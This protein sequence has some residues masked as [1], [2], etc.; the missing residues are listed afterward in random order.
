MP[1]RSV[2][3]RSPT[4]WPR[5]ADR[6]VQLTDPRYYNIR[7]LELL[8]ELR[9]VSRPSARSCDR[10]VLITG[11]GGQ[12]ARPRGLR[13]ARRS[14]RPR[15]R[16]LDIT[17]DEAVARAFEAPAPDVVFNCAAFHN[18]EVCERQEDRLE[19]NVRAVD[20]WRSAARRRREARARVHQLRLRRHRVPSRTGGRTPGAAHVYAL[21]KLAGEYAAL[22]YAP[23]A[24]V[25]RS[26]G[27][28]GFHGSASQGRQLRAADARARPRA[29]RAAGGGRPAA[30][31]DL[32]R[33]PRR[34]L[35]AAVERRRRGLLHLTNARRVLLARVHR[36]HRRAGRPRRP[37]R[38][39]GRR[40]RARRPRP[41][42]N[43]V[44]ARDRGRLA[45]APLARGARR[46]HDAR[47]PRR[48]RRPL[49]D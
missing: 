17:D 47:G 45:A 29:G 11:G 15:A 32:H 20:G 22:A 35:L 30:A 12:L 39:V 48:R 31:P 41:A 40:A 14:P 2:V 5:R 38:A 24:L 46:L 16:R 42:A 34:A 23:G 7:W 43:G 37:G 8:H 21:S 33:R 28:Y 4:C 6:P 9:R 3:R 10:A 18:V 13:G 27:L 26:A 1:A 49:D 19:A 36:G 25:V 44:L